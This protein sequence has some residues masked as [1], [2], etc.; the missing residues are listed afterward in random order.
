[1]IYMSAG[2]G[3]N[4]IY[5]YGNNVCKSGRGDEVQVDHDYPM[6]TDCGNSRRAKACTFHSHAKANRINNAATLNTSESTQRIPLTRD[7]LEKYSL[8]IFIF[9]IFAA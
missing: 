8:E 9:S 6:T 4:A 2:T 1:M 7:L 3:G 5:G